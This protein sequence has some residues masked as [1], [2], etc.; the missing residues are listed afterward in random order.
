MN[1]TDSQTARITD[2]KRR[3]LLN[4]QGA[5]SVV[6]ATSASVDDRLQAIVT[7]AGEQSTSMQAV[8][9]DVTE[10]SSSIEAIAT[11]AEEVS[12]R[13]Q[14]ATAR[15]SSG[16]DSATTAMDR[17]SELH[18]LVDSVGAELQSLLDRIDDIGRTL[19]GID[20][21]AAQTNMLAL[22][23]SI[24]AAR[25]NND[26]FAVVA[27]EIKTLAE[28]AQTQADD[29]ETTLQSVRSAADSTASELDRALS[30]IDNGT[31]EVADALQQ[32]EV[33]AKQ[34]EQISADITA[35]SETTDQQARVSDTVTRRCEAVADRAAG[36]TEQIDGID[37][38]RAEQTAMIGEI[39]RVLE[40][41]TPELAP[42]TLDRIP[43]GIEPIDAAA[44]GGLLRG[45]QSVIRHDI[46]VADIV[47]TLC[48]TA[49]AS[50]YAVSLMPPD[51]VDR[52]MLADELAAG[53]LSYGNAIEKNRL[54]VLD[55]FDRWPSEPN[56]FDGH[57]TPLS[58]INEQTARRRDHPLLI[59][60]NI[61]GEI[62]ALGE[63]TARE[64]RYEND[65]SVFEP[66]DTVCNIVDER[67]VDET[68]GAFYSGA[69]DQ[70]FRLTGTNDGRTIELL[71]GPS[72]ATGPHRLGELHTADSIHGD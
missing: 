27:E 59:V 62:A 2:Q 23:A 48:L 36:I 31:D 51:S 56:V 47:T 57:A 68:F 61:A 12:E 71:G 7:D 30:E 52:Q 19:A 54:F 6:H 14:T 50:G 13:S 26:S 16:H 67:T 40:E 10:L 3:L 25:A 8:V 34:I 69:A 72:G 15:A 55:M 32:L 66:T 43:T 37:S 60:G 65:V 9:E 53:D 44:D 58:R 49:L 5:V 63:E 70:V 64:A 22:N 42:G 11:S 20:Q 35:I 29:I 24:E 1:E 33:V 46:D 39:E 4:A 18:D 45:G 17:M 21:I 38:A 28:E 41:A